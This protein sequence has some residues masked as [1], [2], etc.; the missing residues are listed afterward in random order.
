MAKLAAIAL[1]VF[2]NGFFVAAEF[3]LVKVRGSQLEALSAE[4]NRGAGVARQ[5]M[6]E[7]RCLSGLPARNYPRQSWPWLG[8]RTSSSLACCNR[9][10]HWRRSQSSAII[11]AASFRNRF[12]PR[13]RFLHIVLGEQAPKNSRDSQG[14]GRIDCHQSAATFVLYRFQACDLVPE[15]FVELGLAILLRG[16][17]L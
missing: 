1:L 14:A 16:S 4:G 5:V 15:R 7:S 13:S 11:H 12:L 6:G 10:S 8:R 2:L 3:A 9:F 17:S